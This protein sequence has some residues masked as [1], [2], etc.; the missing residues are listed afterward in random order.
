MTQF[1]RSKV[2]NNNNRIKLFFNLQSVCCISICIVLVLGLYLN[3]YITHKSLKNHHRHQHY[4]QDVTTGNGG[5]VRTIPRKSTLLSKLPTPSL[6][7]GFTTLVYEFFKCNQVASQHFCCCGDTQDHYPCPTDS[8]ASCMLKNLAI[9]IQ[10]KQKQPQEKLQQANMVAETMICMLKWM[11]DDLCEPLSNKSKE[12]QDDVSCWMM[13]PLKHRIN[14]FANATVKFYS[15]ILYLNISICN[16]YT[17]II[18]QQRIYYHSEIHRL[19]PIPSWIG[20]K[21]VH[22]L[23]VNTCFTIQQLWRNDQANMELLHF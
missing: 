11:V 22:D 10:Q 3:V 23:S 13:I 5:M 9:I 18:L 4:T 21:C 6:V 17:T 1:Q 2:Q 19:G 20:F 8:M 14:V 7:V 12:N 15:V 16:N